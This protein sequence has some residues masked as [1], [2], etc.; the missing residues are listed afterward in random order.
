MSWFV[1]FIVGASHVVKLFVPVSICMLIVILTIKTTSLFYFYFF[2]AM[3]S[4]KLTSF[5]SFIHSWWC[6]M[7]VRDSREMF[8]KRIRTMNRFFFVFFVS[9][10]P[11]AEDK[12]SNTERI[13]FSLA[14]TFIFM[15]FVIVATIILILLYKFK[16]YKV[17]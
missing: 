1:L 12:T 17:Q 10:T 15:G 6:Y 4:N 5:F 11:F 9:Y 7:G 8:F 13:L 14:N 3:D 2:L 16:C